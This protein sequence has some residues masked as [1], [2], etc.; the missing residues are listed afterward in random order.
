MGAML[1][2][3]DGCNVTAYRWVQCYCIQMGAMLLH[4]DGCNVTA[5]ELSVVAVA[6]LLTN[7]YCAHPM[8]TL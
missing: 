8:T 5:C 6:C 7:A 3:T 1:L 4:A 2:H